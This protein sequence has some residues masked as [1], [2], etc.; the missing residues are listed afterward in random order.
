MAN[1]QHGRQS[2]LKSRRI[3]ITIITTV[4]EKRSLALQR[5]N[6]KPM[7]APANRIYSII[8]SSGHCFIFT[9]ANPN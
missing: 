7:F 2:G 4:V 1:A 8:E 3:R 6:I 9:N 5:R